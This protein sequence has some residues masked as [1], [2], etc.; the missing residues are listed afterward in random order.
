MHR[1]M[2]KSEAYQQSSQPDGMTVKED[3]GNILFSRMPLQRM[4]AEV[5]HDSILRVVGR[6]D[7]TPFGEPV[8]VEKHSNGEI[9]PK[10]SDQGRR[11]AIYVLKRRRTPLTL[12]DVFDLP[13]LSPN[14]TERTVSNVAP[15][16]LQLLNSEKLIEDARF[17]A[18]RLIDE[19][20]RQPEKQLRSLYRRV[21][22]RAPTEKETKSFEEDLSLLVFSWR[23][24]LEEKRFDAPRDA[25]AQW[26]A[27]G[28]LAHALLNS[29]EFI[30][31]D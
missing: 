26:Y 23:S 9:L 22:S 15:Q 8:P 17:L 25:T 31:I 7:D 18:A 21:L 13:R 5:L 3:P 28:S 16:A 29:A 2:M 14:C 24:H 20:P 10:P 11:R 19:Y 27:L 12:L 4:S 30:Y 6:L 1:L